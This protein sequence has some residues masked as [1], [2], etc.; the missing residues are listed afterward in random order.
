MSGCYGEV[1]IMID[2]EVSRWLIEKYNLSGVNKTGFCPV[3]GTAATTPSTR[4]E[5]YE[6]S[7]LELIK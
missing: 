3:I 4:T 2:S 7:F 1:D 5:R 6:V